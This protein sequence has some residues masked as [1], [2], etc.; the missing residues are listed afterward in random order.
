MQ[1]GKNGLNEKYLSYRQLRQN[2]GTVRCSSSC[3]LSSYFQTFCK[4]NDLDPLAL[5][6]VSF[7]CFLLVGVVPA[8]RAVF[9]RTPQIV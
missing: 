2:C 1:K 9:F 6:V 4:V 7:Q 8:S 5:C 3:L